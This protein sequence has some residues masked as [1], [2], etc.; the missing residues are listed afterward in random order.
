VS[1]SISGQN[2]ATYEITRNAAN[3]ARGTSLVVA[4]LDEVTQAAVGTRA[5]AE[6]VLTASNSVDSSIGSL[7]TEIE[8]FLGKVAV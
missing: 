4:A 6:T 7:R 2:A 1:S 8:A 5:A 3:A